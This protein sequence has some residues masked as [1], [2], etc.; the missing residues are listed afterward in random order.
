MKKVFLFLLMALASF[1]IITSCGESKKSKPAE[2]TKLA[3]YKDGV[4]AFSYPENWIKS[5]KQNEAVVAFSSEAGKLRFSK[6]DPEG[7]FGAMFSFKAIKLN[8]GDVVE[9]VMKEQKIFDASIYT[10]PEKFMVDGVELNKQTY[11]Y[12]LKDGMFEGEIYYGTKDGSFLSI[13]IFEAFGGTLSNFRSYI[14]QSLKAT[15]LA[16]MPTKTEGQPQVVKVEADPPS[17]NLTK[18]NGD[19]YSIG[20]P[21]NFEL[22]RGARKAAGVLSATDYM[23]DRRADCNIMVEVLDGK[24][25]NL[26]KIA[27]T[28][29]GKLGG[30]AK[31]TTLSGEKAFQFDY[32]PVAG[33]KGRMSLALKNGKLYRVTINWSKDEEASYKP[34]FEKSV[35]SFKFN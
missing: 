19:G 2:I 32:N 28:L 5:I 21:D 35:A 31:A 24:D 13:M 8:A 14:D 6:T 7:D 33:V 9:T 20:I 27:N 25:A 23:G 26:E 1:A 34:I 11:K 4:F 12:D 17:A 16:V 29:A 30:A 15:K 3:E 18:M 22:N 10:S